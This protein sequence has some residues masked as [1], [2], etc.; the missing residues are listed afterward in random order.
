MFKAAD[1][2]L[3]RH[4]GINVP[5]RRDGRIVGVFG[6][7]IPSDAVAPRTEAGTQLTPRQLDVLRLL[8]QAKSTAEIAEELHLSLETVRNHIAHLFKAL[9]A[10]NRLEAAIIGIRDGLVSVELE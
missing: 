6:M 9:G 1:G 10:H 4:E 3:V 7:A 5:I 2:R 8:V